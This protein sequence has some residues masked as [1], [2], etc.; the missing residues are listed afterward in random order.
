VKRAVAV[1]LLGAII[2]TVLYGYTMTRRERL[3]RRA[4]LQGELAMT[5]GDAFGAISHFDEAIGLKPDAMLGYLKRGEARVR[6]GELE[7]ASSD[8]AA[9]SAR[10]ATASRALE[11]R[12]DV[13]LAR[14]RPEG[15]AEHFA[16][17]IRLDDRAP[18]VL[19]KLGLARLLMGR[20]VDAADT[21]RGAVALDPTLADAYYLLG[22]CLR[23]M[24][25]PRDAQRQ[26]ERAI[27]LA[28]SLLPARE[29]LADLYGA[30]GNRAGRIRQLEALFDADPRAGRQ[31]ALALAYADANQTTRAVNLLGRATERYPDDAGTYVALGRVWLEQARNGDR[32][33]LGK[34]IDA[35]EHAAAMEPTSRGLGLLGE[36]RLLGPDP[37]LAEATL[38]QAIAEKPPVDRSTFLHLAQSAERTGDAHTARNALLDYY[39]LSAPTE[40]RRADIA[41]RIAELSVRLRDLH[42]AAI[43]YANAAAPSASPSEL[44]EVATAQL[45]LGDKAGALATLDRLLEKDPGNDEARELRA[46]AR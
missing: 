35:L 21:L 46:N 30:A 42:A 8:F 20:P 27:S 40:R 33:A 15:A 9:A 17:F 38:R 24:Q 6:R 25:R 3:Y 7:A 11:L 18:R 1:L 13:E 39:S 22:I 29:Q 23:E 10:D 44:L 5:R 28:P 14:Q 45:R 19:Y 26:L 41:R 12:G 36:A 4:V 2:A 32:V 34:A 37:A 43:W 16:A 31:L